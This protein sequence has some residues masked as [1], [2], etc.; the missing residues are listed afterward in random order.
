M[1]EFNHINAGVL[2]C[3]QCGR[4]WHVSDYG[5]ECP[6]CEEEWNPVTDADI[7]HN[8]Y[9]PLKETV[10]GFMFVKTALKKQTGMKI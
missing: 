10:N 7:T 2:I 1:Y 5:F 3:N 9:T 6:E 8:S 4:A